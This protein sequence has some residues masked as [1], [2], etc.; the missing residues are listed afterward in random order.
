MEHNDV[1]DLKSVFTKVSAKRKMK[2]SGK[3]LATN[4]KRL[5]SKSQ[6]WF[7]SIMAK[8]EHQRLFPVKSITMITT[9]PSWRLTH[10]FLGKIIILMVELPWNTVF[11]V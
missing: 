1:D 3:N 6:G 5:F 10:I 11:A 8:P 7:W 4:Q 9:I 2:G